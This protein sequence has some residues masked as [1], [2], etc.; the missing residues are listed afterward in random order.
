MKPLV[1]AQT[2]ND[3]TGGLCAER[4]V[5]EERGGLHGRFLV[6]GWEALPKGLWAESRRVRGAIR[7][8]LFPA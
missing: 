2:D 3:A 5:G 6:R 8:N 7:G 1:A 4:P